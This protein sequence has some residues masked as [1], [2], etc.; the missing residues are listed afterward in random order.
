VLIVLG[1]VSLGAPPPAHAYIDPL[2][3]SVVFQALIA[4]ALGA[5]LTVKHWWAAAFRLVRAV[6]T[7]VTGR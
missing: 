1:V 6:F 3:G 4:G 2:S 7:R 5:L